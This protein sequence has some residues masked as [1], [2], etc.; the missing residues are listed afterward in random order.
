M[1]IPKILQII[2]NHEYKILSRIYIRVNL[3]HNNKMCRLTM[4]SHARDVNRDSPT[5]AVESSEDDDSPDPNTC[6]LCD[7]SP[8]IGYGFEEEYLQTSRLAQLKARFQNK[9]NNQGKP[10][11]VQHFMMRFKV[12]R[13]FREWAWMPKNSRIP[14]CVRK[15][16]LQYFPHTKSE[17]VPVHMIAHR[18]RYKARYCNG[19]AVKGYWWQQAPVGHWDLVD[20]NADL[21]REMDYPKNMLAIEQTMCTVA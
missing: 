13:K 10:Y 17:S 6:D 1:N 11:K 16:I 12:T 14:D 21:V 20:E 2:C 3:S 8:C 4:V 15:T 9:I 5:R 7:C 19:S 18:I